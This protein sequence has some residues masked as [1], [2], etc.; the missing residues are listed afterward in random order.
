MVDQLQRSGI[1]LDYVDVDA[2]P[3][4][5]FYRWL[6]A[7]QDAN[8]LYVMGNNDLFHANCFT[9]IQNLPG[10][11]ILHDSRLFE[12]LLN[13]FGPAYIHGLWQ[14]R[15]GSKPIGI[16]TVVDWQRERR[17]LPD[18][19]LDPLVTRALAIL[20]H[21][22]I[23]AEH[24]RRTYGFNRVH[25]LPFALQMT[26]TEVEFVTSMRGARQ[27]AP[28]APIVLTMLGET[29]PTKACVELVFALKILVLQGFDVRLHFVGKSDD[30]YHAELRAAADTLG[31][32]DRIVFARF[33]SRQVY[34]DSI[35][36]ADIIV[37]LRYPLFG[38]VSGPLAD[39]VA[40][41]VPVVATEEFAVG[42]G[43]SENCAVIANHFSPLHIAEAVRHLIDG[44]TRLAGAR[45]NTMADYTSK[46]LQIM[47]ATERDTR[48]APATAAS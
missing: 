45:F 35:V 46:L 48:R 29:D 22:D 17:L 37:Q 6:A 15:H 47:R 11:C 30:P 12:F 32:A 38:Q 44:K 4:A 2:M 20:V 27:H 26:R 14:R 41:G 34:L 7:H 43:V 1:E 21:N 33:V 8:I 16:E 36:A 3:P 24:I 25:Y 42:M 40:C 19:F 23:S 10:V 31:L 28:D 18:S 9:A 5:E 39:A 13:R